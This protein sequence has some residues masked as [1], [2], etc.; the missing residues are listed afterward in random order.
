M[1]KPA[2]RL[3][4][5]A[6]WDFQ[7]LQR[8]HDACE[9]IAKGELGLDTYPNQ[10]EIITAEQM[11]DA[12]S[13]VGMPLFYKHWSFGKHFA[14]HEASYR[15]GLM[16]LAYEI[17]INSSPCISYLMEGNTAT[18]QALVIAHAAFGHNHFFK[19]NYLFRQWTDADGILD[20]LDFAKSYVAQ[21]EERHGRL[22]VEV[23]LDAA[24][25]L[26]SHGIDRYPGKKKPDLRT[27][28]KRAAR[29]RLHEES[30]FNDLWRTVP[31]GPAKS[32]A[33][34]DV[35]RRRK[36]LGLPQENL[37][38]FLEKSAP[39]LAPWQRKLLRIVRH[40]A[41]YFYPQS[42]TKVMNEGTATYVHYRIMNRLYEQGRISDGNFLEFLQSHTNVVFQPDFEHAGYSGF[43]PYALGFAMMRDIERIVTDPNDEDREWFPDIAGTGDVMGVLRNVW[44][45]YRDESFIGQ[46]LSPRLM[47]HFRM[48]HLHDD[49][50]EPAG[51]R[52][53]AIHD[54]RGYRR[55]RREL[56]RQY[57]VGFT[58]ANIEIVDVDLAGDRRL[59][60]R[61]FVVNGAQLNETDAKRVLQ[62]LADLW[63]Y[64][65]ALVEVDTNE[66][67]LKEYVLNPRM[68]TAAA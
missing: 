48:F 6:D 23:T 3:F 56:A 62:H 65:V 33:V 20:Y 24:H 28:E 30:A 32:N 29:R 5:G 63:S 16:G 35:E 18:M 8:I 25:A 22:A 15:K 31:T 60:L 38:Y 61:H 34:Q 66:R 36:L 1:S 4:N 10:I 13:S 45:N 17:V 44:A 9:E 40:I 12:Y 41:Q 27:E 26:M 64:D 37:L 68:I 7:I 14:F 19:N 11:L 51:I 54:E 46:F 53:D 52:V 42:Q 21:C 67:V 55:V 50:E 43:N 47:R 2:E 57:D 58:D 49:P 39:R 59:M